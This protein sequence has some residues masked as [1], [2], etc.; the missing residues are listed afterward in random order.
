MGSIHDA[1]M[2]QEI[3]F[4]ALLEELRELFL[5]DATIDN[6]IDETEYIVIY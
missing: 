2:I 6:K 4:P 1:R 5:V 3:D